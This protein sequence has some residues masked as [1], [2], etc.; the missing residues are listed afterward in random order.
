MWW[1]I[2]LISIAYVLLAAHFL[3]FGQMPLAITCVLLPLLLL[4]KNNLMTRLIQMGL[5]IA[6]LIVWAP[7]TYQYINLRITMNE[8]WYLLATIMGTVITFS[9]FASYCINGLVNPPRDK[10]CLFR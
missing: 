3:R 7:A 2:I 6:T 10:N 4:L 1:R 9:F 8:P 5:I